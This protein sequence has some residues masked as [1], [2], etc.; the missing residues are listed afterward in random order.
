MGLDYR[1]RPLRAGVEL[2]VFHPEKER[3]DREDDHR[4]QDHHEDR[5]G[6]HHGRE[7]D[8]RNGDNHDERDH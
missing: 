3:D 6:S 4:G 5:Q 2:P 7:S 8:C 1:A